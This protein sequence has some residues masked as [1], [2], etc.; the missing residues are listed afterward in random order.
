VIDSSSSHLTAARWN[1]N[2]QHYRQK[3]PSIKVG[4]CCNKVSSNTI[5]STIEVFHKHIFKVVING[6]GDIISRFS[7]MLASSS[8]SLAWA[9]LC[10]VQLTSS[11]T[12]GKF[13]RK[14]S[15]IYNTSIWYSIQTNNQTPYPNPAIY[16]HKTS[17]PHRFPEIDGGDRITEDQASTPSTYRRNFKI[18][19]SLPVFSIV[20]APSFELPAGMYLA[21][22]S[23]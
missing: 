20:T 6:K 18:L 5:S 22:V 13:S 11:S 4:T 23:N 3:R 12:C 8:A 2:G 21:N 7:T 19:W 16:P 17:L 15:R 14:L 9:Y 1:A 10:Q